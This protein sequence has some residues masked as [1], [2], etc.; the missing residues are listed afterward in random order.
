MKLKLEVYRAQINR[1]LNCAKMHF[2][3]KMILVW[4]GDKL[5][6]GQSQNGIN[7][8]IDDK[9]KSNN[10]HM[11]SSIRINQ[12]FLR[13]V[14]RLLPFLSL[15]ILVLWCVENVSFRRINLLFSFY[16]TIV[17]CLI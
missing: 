2:W 14:D 15:Y 8:T 10:M 5:S 7:L 16:D 3:S 12:L 4:T 1:D 6:C 11:Y 13:S 17:H 9:Y